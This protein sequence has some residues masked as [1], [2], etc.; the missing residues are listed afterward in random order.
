MQ[1]KE[2]QRVE[3]LAATE[4]KRIQK[5]LLFSH[6]LYIVYPQGGKVIQVLFSVIWLCM[7]ACSIQ[8]CLCTREFSVVIF[9]FNRKAR[10]TREQLAELTASRGS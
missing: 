7:L 5:K 2:M 8:L 3:L 4:H 9:H 6:P 1:N 10:R